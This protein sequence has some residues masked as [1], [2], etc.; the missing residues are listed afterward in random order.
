MSEDIRAQL[1]SP[2][3]RIS[4]V[5]LLEAK[6]YKDPKTGKQSEPKFG[7][8]MIIEP[9]DLKHFKQEVDGKLVDVDVSALSKELVKKKWPELEI[10][11]MFPKKPNGDR[12]WPIKKGDEIIAIAAKSDK[13]SKLDFL[14]GKYQ[15][16]TS[17]SQKMPPR[18][19][20]KDPV[21]SKVITLD[22]DNPDDVK[23]IKKLFNSGNYGI[24]EVSL[25]PNEVNGKC[26]LTFYL[27]H[28]R[29]KKEGERIGGTSMMDRFDGIDG[30]EG[31]LDPTDG[32]DD[33]GDGI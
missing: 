18:L 30:G 5:Q 24:C 16:G 22:R 9:D 32:A 8:A 20:Y 7:L 3:V 10:G 13:K 21:E 1:I 4:R 6:P 17:A 23:K 2:L 19:S 25:V 31:D 11:E 27:N 12:D 15:I 14:A 28:V 33:F 29:F 26:Y